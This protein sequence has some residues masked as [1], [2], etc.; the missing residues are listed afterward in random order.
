MITDLSWKQRI[1]RKFRTLQERS[2]CSYNW[3]IIRRMKM[4]NIGDMN[5]KIEIYGFGWDKDELGQK[6]RKKKS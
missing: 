6:I 1:T 3:K 2:Y 4:I 5:K